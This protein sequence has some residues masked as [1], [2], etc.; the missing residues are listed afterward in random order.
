MKRLLWEELPLRSSRALGDYAD[1]FYL[2]HILGD[3]SATPFPAQRLS[4]TRFF[5]ADHP[6]LITQAFTAKLE[7]FGWERR[8][9]TDNV[10]SWTIVEF[11]APVPDGVEVWLCGYGKED[12]DS[13][14][15]I[16]N[17]ADQMRYIARL[18][19]RDDDFSGLRAECSALD[20]R[21]KVRLAERVSIKAAIDSLAE[22]SGIIWWSGG[23]RL[24]PTSDGPLT[25]LDLDRKEA[26]DLKPSANLSDTADVLRISYD[27]S[28]ASKRALRYMELTAFPQR[29]GG[30]AKEVVYGALTSPA[31]AEAIGRP[32]LQRL[33]GQR[34]DMPFNSTARIRPGMDVRLVDNPGWLIDDSDPV[35]TVLSVQLEPSSGAVSVAGETIVGRSVVTVTA[36]SVAL[37]DT[38]QESVNV[39]IA[40]GIATFTIRDESGRGIKGAR[41]SLD[42]SAARTTDALGQ[43]RFPQTP[44]THTLIVELGGK[45][46]EV[47]VPM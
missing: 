6:M 25:V 1:D 18:G 47:S 35:V 8:L 40:D 43:V 41:A 28:P 7:A 33:N 4:E 22:S 36:F 37:P 17:P 39:E 34:Y 9:E 12:D 23:A 27:Y 44:G 31:N 3:W 21:T 38:V 10:R 19:E 5:A 20:L 2:Q 24:Y 29:Y 13:G 26:R 42:G 30:M 16:E 11:A 15:L 32:V 46:Y 45:V 14:E